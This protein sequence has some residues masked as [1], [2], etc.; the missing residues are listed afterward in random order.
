MNKIVVC[1]SREWTDYSKIMLRLKALHPDSLVI[2]GGAK[3]ADSL[4]EAVCAKLGMHTAV[5]RPRWDAFGKTAGHIRN[6]VM[7]DLEPSLVI[8]FS[9]G[10]GGTQNTINGARKRGIS[11]EVIGQEVQ[12]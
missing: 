2:H 6:A 10:T 1:G 11:V 4:A 12:P 3:G 9:R 7:L 5:V 8:A